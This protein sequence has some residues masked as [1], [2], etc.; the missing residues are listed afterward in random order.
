MAEIFKAKRKGVKGFEKVIALKKIL[1]GYGKDDK[2][3]EMFV[4]EAK[5]AAELTHPNIVQIYDLGVK[6]DYYFIA[7]EYVSGKDLR[8]ILRKLS[9]SGQ[10]LPEELSLYLILE[11]LKA[12]NYA[13]SA[14]DS[15][16]KNLEIVH[17]DISPPNILV[18]FTGD[19]KLTDFGVSKASIKMHQTVA[20]ALK[21]KLLYMSPEQARAE[22]DID[23]RADLYSV[24]II[25]FELI[26]GE[27]LFMDSSDMA[28]LHKV[29]TGEIIK[30]GLLKKDIDPQLE[31]IILRVLNKDKNKRYQKASDII[32]DIHS[33][34]LR[35]Y[36]RPALAVHLSHAIYDL[37]K[38][39]IEKEGIKIDLKPIPYKINRL[40][41]IEMEPPPPPA[42]A[43]PK[44][45]TQVIT[46]PV[47]QEPLLLEKQ[48]T[49]VE[50]EE[51][52][53]PLVEI[54]LDDDQGP[55][56]APA[57]QPSQ[58][59][60][61][62]PPPQPS[63]TTPTT[64]L[65]RNEFL[66]WEDEGEPEDKAKAA[67]STAVRAEM[68]F[69]A[70][71]ELQ[72]IKDEETRKRKKYLYI[73]LVVIIILG[74]LITYYLITGKSTPGETIEPAPQSETTGTTSPQTTV[75]APAPTTETPTTSEETQAKDASTPPPTQQPELKKEPAVTPTTQDTQ[76]KDT[77][78]QKPV[79]TPPVTPPKENIPEAKPEQKPKPKEEPKQEPAV[80]QEALKQKQLEEEANKKALADEEAKKTEEA[81]KQLEAQ[82]NK[83]SE[84]DIIAI[85]DA[86]SPPAAISTPA[87]EITPQDT[88]TLKADEIV[89]ASY[90]VDH[91]GTVSE[92]RLIKRSS[93]K[94]INSVIEKTITG[95]KFKPA[96]KN[97]VR[98]KVWKTITLT[99]KK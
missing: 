3:I 53:H 63:K 52:F 15:S 11:V 37:F 10:L 71:S 4:D 95:W 34:L 70:L 29:Q 82:Q 81:Q 44:L 51:D 31:F 25:F 14:K 33:Y 12:L 17:R 7:M 6:D 62:P 75:P 40:Q 22:K 96:T 87:V 88:R 84:G 50:L 60:P 77:A 46:T 41:R 19:V 5:I 86:D 27:K 54:D 23:H 98:V 73:A 28:V 36:D 45:I 18:S 67:K 59:P 78:A 39:E 30:P 79:E 69:S 1:A 90:L 43:P 21:G 55:A 97:N 94:K 56:Q 65:E 68:E 74:I 47:E 16:G 24:G 91:N 38:E 48:D 57:P 80:D 64:I 93:A 58:P 49:L 92:V 42:P 26:T 61:P 32:N 8:L 35:N 20:G 9:D 72:A 85:S 13:H 83:I 76:A 66:T 2:Y 89:M 99:I